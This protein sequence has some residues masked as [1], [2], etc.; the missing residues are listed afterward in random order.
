MGLRETLVSYVDAV[1]H[2]LFGGDLDEVRPPTCEH[3]A[4]AAAVERAR[5]DWLAARSYFEH[6]TDPRLVDYAIL[7]MGAAERRYMFLLDEA[8]RQGVRVHP[9]ARDAETVAPHGRRI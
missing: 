6:V 9:L 1:A 5:K 7:S 4:L 2:Y 8:R 3:T